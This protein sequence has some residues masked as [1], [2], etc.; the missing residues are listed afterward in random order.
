MLT[1]IKGHN[2][3][4]NELKITGNNLNLDNVNIN[5]YTKFGEVLSICSPYIE[6]KR[7]SY[8]NQGP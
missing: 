5:A 1:S 2:F 4:T 8:I 3:V 6:W 7:N